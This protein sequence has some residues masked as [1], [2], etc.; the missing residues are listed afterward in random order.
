MID[1]E[2]SLERLG[3]AAPH[4]R[5]LSN[6][7]YTVLLTG[8]GTGRS[9]CDGYA[10]TS[11]S[12][13]RTEDG[14][15][16][17]LYL[18]DLDDDVLWSAAFHPVRRV[19][20]QLSATWV[21]GHV[22]L[23]RR[24]RGIESTVEACVAPGDAIEIR[25]LRLRNVSERARRI[26]VTSYLEVVLSDPAA[27]A[28]HPAF[29]KL[30]VETEYARDVEVLLARR[31][32]RSQSEHHPWM[33]HALRGPGALEVETD[34]VRFVGRGRSIARPRALVSRA[35][36]S[37]T[38]GA[39]LDPIFSTRRV[40]TLEPGAQTELTLLV[41]VA[42]TRDDA[43]ALARRYETAAAVDGALAA[44][45]EAERRLLRELGLQ[46]DEAERWQDLAVAMLYGD[47]DLRADPA[48]LA[49]ASGSVATLGAYGVRA[50]ALVVLAV[51]D[52]EAQLQ[53]VG[54]LGRAWR[55]WTAK[56][57][58]VDVVFLC[59]TATLGDEVGRR[60][61]EAGD[62]MSGLVV[63]L[64]DTIPAQ[65][66]D[67]LLACA[68]LALGARRV[69]GKAQ[70]K[71][72]AVASRAAPPTRPAGDPARR[73]TPGV[74]ATELLLDNG[75]GG[76]RPDGREYVVRVKPA[77]SDD[78][79][80]PPMPWVN[81][82]AN[83]RFGF[84]LS[85]AGAGYTWSRNSRENR[86]TPW[87]ND[88]LLDPHGEALY[89]RD[90]E[91]GAF[92]SPLAGPAAPAALVEVRHGFGYT[93]VAHTSHDLAQEVVVFVP[94]QPPDPLKI[95]VVRLRNLAERPR[96][97][98]LFA[99]QR[100]VLGVL[101]SESG[102]F[103]VTEHDAAS[104]AL[105]ARSGF[106]GEFSGA[107]V[108]AATLAPAGAASAWSGDRT[109]FIGRNGSPA[110]PAAI[111][112]GAT[113]D[114]RTG[115]GLDPCAALQTT[116]DIAPGAEVEVAF[117][118]GEA[119]DENE[120]REL[121]ARYRTGGAI[122]SALDGTR[123]FWRAQLDTLWIETPSPAIDLVVNGWLAYQTLSCRL[124]GRS[125]LYQSGGAFG[126]RDQL[127]DSAVFLM[128][129]PARTRAQILLHAAH[130]FVEG[131]VL[132]WWHPPLDKG[133]RTRFS[134]DLLWL[135]Y[136]A[137]AYVHTTG[138]WSLLDEVTGFVTARPLEPGEDETFLVPS[139][140]AERADVY[141][142]CCR[143][144]DRS[145]TAGAH[146]LPLMGSG[147]WNDGM[148]RVG[149]E[150][151]GES[152]WLGFFLFRLIDDFVPL[153]ERRGDHERIARYRAYQTRLRGALE[154]A[155]WDGAWYRRAYYDDGTPLGSAASQE[156]RIDALAQAWAVLSGAAPRKR[157]VAAMDAVERE[158]ISEQDGII[159]LLTPP[160][161]RD[162]HDPGYIK[163]Y[164]PGIRENG[165]QYT[166]AALWV[167]Q[168][169]AA[170]GRR[171]RA[172]A[173]LAMLSPVSHARSNEATARY[174]VEPYVVAADVYSVPPH[175]GRGGWTWYTGSA[176]WMR[177]IAVESILG[178]RIVGGDTLVIEP[179]IPDEWPQFTLRLRLPNGGSVYAI[180]VRNP[181]RDASTIASVTVDQRPGTIEAGAARVP[182]AT[183]G[184]MHT[185]EV[186]LGSRLD[187]TP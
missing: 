126:F 162:P 171:D 176:G 125:A 100:L 13:D 130:Q 170:L 37:G 139:L 105:F 120:A 151:R 39:V 138:D 152:V 94:Q 89:V 123:A 101:P 46:P 106:N 4:G 177:R 38:T 96:R 98:S 104:G 168:A 30:F 181:E 124:W 165:G 69:R 31:R 7:R 66:V 26:E 17:F 75:Y 102:R 35:A 109:A 121:S 15:G 140:A 57:L 153:C 59:G 117:L 116:V 131:D 173:L 20:E 83:E 164:V 180:T 9:T 87:L 8:A 90:D 43:L 158:L 56:A 77:S 28:A 95:T 172:A 127:Q 146:G 76:F 174:Q 179:C 29:A 45:V 154:E 16:V 157:A 24:D 54:P 135:P 52:C 72:S 10:L 107:T 160:F 2:S 111:V 21:P 12:G 82:V 42:P 166:H 41:G 27:H 159:R 55:Y 133:I 14:D 134:D 1:R 186:V 108:F 114:R 167:V 103:V 187:S 86:L 63:L 32:P 22:G 128:T 129:D 47:P 3:D 85:E 136:F 53:T 48:V 148:N 34:R 92:W 97:V 65:H 147:D 18:R 155:G 99:Y 141:A 80:R 74:A 25:R 6:G 161:D 175:V 150:G 67:L 78:A 93:S 169:F 110:A 112:A 5:L 50:A 118:F 122:A 178:V 182:I 137:A 113:L 49:R 58:L 73:E 33:L 64:R 51:V 23:T 119:A 132:H 183:D 61:R 156:C 84:L 19:A 11:W 144:I 71:A 142:H 145:L 149:R 88:P 81:V 91:T 44:A 36:L 40:A 62:G 185:I 184:G 143:A 115:A 60:W 79:G 70:Q 163:G 68:H